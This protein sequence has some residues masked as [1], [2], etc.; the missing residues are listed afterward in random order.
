MSERVDKFLIAMD[1]RLPAFWRFDQDSPFGRIYQHTLVPLRVIL[2]GGQELDGKDWVHFSMSH[3]ERLPS[4][5][6]LTAAK[7][8]F[9]GDVYAYQVLPPKAKYININPKVLHLFY[10]L[11]GVPLPDF[12]RGTPSL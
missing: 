4:W 10:C 11:D 3:R 5:E 2:T 7:V 12:T 1:I 9:L 8:H 6:E